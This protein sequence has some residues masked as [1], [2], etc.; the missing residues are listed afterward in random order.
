MQDQDSQIVTHAHSMYNRRQ[1][2]VKAAH[3]KMSE[4]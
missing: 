2:P 3:L 4:E 1:G